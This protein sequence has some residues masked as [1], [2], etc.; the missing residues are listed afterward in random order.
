MRE[1]HDAA[2][3][4]LWPGRRASDAHEAATKA[5]RRHGF[6]A[7]MVTDTAYHRNP[8][9]HLPSDT[10]EKLD[11]ERMSQVTLGL[12]GMLRELADQTR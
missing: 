3:F 4:E 9:Y 8:H 1:A 2:V 10:P 12:A 11:Y 7:L 5:L 6:P